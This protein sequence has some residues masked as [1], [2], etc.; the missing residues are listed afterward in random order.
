MRCIFGNL[1]DPLKQRPS[2][3][4]PRNPE[5]LHS[6]LYRFSPFFLAEEGPMSAALCNTLLCIASLLV[7]FRGGLATRIY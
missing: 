7:G 2:P 5:H 3:R 1:D 4:P 6:I